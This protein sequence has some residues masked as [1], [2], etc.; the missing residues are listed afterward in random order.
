VRR[1]SRGLS[2]PVVLASV[3]VLAACG[4]M[5]SPH[6]PWSHRPAPPPEAVHELVITSGDAAAPSTAL[7]F[8]QYWKRNTLVLDLQGA[9][10]TGGVV[11]RPKVG[12]TWPIRL[13]LRVMPGAIGQLEVRADQRLVI[14][15]TTQ[16]SKPIDLELAPGIYTATTAEIRVNWAPT[17]PL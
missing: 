7:D 6:W 10:G 3:L 14:P 11:L 2:A 8:P 1:L 16:G 5:P 9:S 12:T 15:V 17:A 4:H 13:A